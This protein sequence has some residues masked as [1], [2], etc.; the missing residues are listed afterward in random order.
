[1]P[2]KFEQDG[3]LAERLLSRSANVGVVDTAWAQQHYARTT[4]FV[5]ER[6]GVLGDLNSRYGTVDGRGANASMPV[7]QGTYAR[8]ETGGGDLTPG[9]AGIQRSAVEV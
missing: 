5:A 3:G 9:D 2:D 4:D 6:F 7:A 1:M 8:A